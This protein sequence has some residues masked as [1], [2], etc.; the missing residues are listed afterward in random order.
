[1]ENIKNT[2]NIIPI[3]VTLP[4]RQAAIPLC[5]SAES[6][7]D[8]EAQLENDVQSDKV[9]INLKFYTMKNHILIFAVI[10]SFLMTS[11]ATIFNSPHKTITVHTTEPSKIVHK[12]DTIRTID[13]K[14]HLRVERKNEPLSFVATTD[15][16]GKSVEVGYIN[17][18]L[19]WLNI[20][21]FNYGIGM[22]VDR[23]NPKRYSYPEKIF[24]NSANTTGEYFRF[25]QANNKGELY[26]HLSLPW[27][28]NSF[29]I[30][31]E[32]EGIKVNFGLGGTTIG[33]D[34]YHSK[35]QFIHLGFSMVSAS[36]MWY[37]TNEREYE[38]MSSNYFS[39]SNNHKIG[40]FSIG[41]GLSYARN[42]WNLYQWQL[43]DDMRFEIP[44]IIRTKSH[45]TV[46]LIFPT[47]FQLGN[48]IN[49]GVI[50]RPTFYR[51]N[52]TD[53]FLYEHLI[54]IDC[55]WKIRL[56]R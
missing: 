27:F 39:L 51:P 38:I 54:S 43:V 13:N 41:Y 35:S 22:L 40:R 20:N 4:L 36:K 14:A 52:L 18:P 47:Y 50:Y 37:T 34:Y 1:M 2:N 25:G 53:Q 42:D 48:Y 45:N 12:Q 33:L 24:I 11:C 55:A 56:K 21:P 49:I 32:N 16:L 46:G 7:V 3:L 8:N 15:S 5:V 9:V 19:F 29:R 26:L 10:V 17:S 6:V 30:M 44:K 23:N 28:F 31:P